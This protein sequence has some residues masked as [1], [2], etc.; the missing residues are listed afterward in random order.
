MKIYVT[1]YIARCM[2]YHKVKVEHRHPVGLL[3]PL[4]I[5]E[6]KWDVVMINLIT[7]FP[8]TRLKNDAIM[9]VVDKLTKY[10]HFIP[11]KTNS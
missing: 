4:P 3:H 2:E 5:L 10:A 1:G 7:N 9:V 6:W 11:M 8:K